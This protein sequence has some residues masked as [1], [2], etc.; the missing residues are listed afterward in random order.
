MWVSQNPFDHVCNWVKDKRCRAE[1]KG[2]CAFYIKL[3]PPGWT[4]MFQYAAS[5]SNVAIRAPGPF[6]GTI[7]II[8][9]TVMY[10]SIKSWGSIPSLTLQPRVKINQQSTTTCLAALVLELLQNC[11][12]L[13]EEAWEKYSL[14]LCPEIPHWPSTRQWL[15]DSERQRDCSFWLAL[16]HRK[17]S[18]DQDGWPIPGK[19]HPLSEV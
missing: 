14:Q 1:T 8:W 15:F 10:W 16:W 17:P 6:W 9:S 7:W 13:D 4:A 3:T 11:W 19:I 12:Y 2:E 18:V 5:T